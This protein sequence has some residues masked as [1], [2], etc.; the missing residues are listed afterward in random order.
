MTSA[1]R[2]LKIVTWIGRAPGMAST[3]QVMRCEI[4]RLSQRETRPSLGL[5]VARTT[6][7]AVGRTRRRPLAAPDRHR[8]R[9]AQP[10]DIVRSSRAPSGA[11]SPI[12]EADRARARIGQ[13]LAPRAPPRR[14]RR[15]AGRRR[16]RKRKRPRPARIFRFP[17]CGV[18]T[19]RSDLNPR[20]CSERRPDHGNRRTPPTFGPGARPR[21]LQDPLNF[22]FYHPLA[23][24]LARLLRPTGI[25]PNMVSVMSLLALIAAAASLMPASPGR[26]ARCSASRFMLAWHVDRRRRRRPRPDDAAAPRRPASWSTASATMPATSSSI[27]PSPS[28]STTG[29]APGPGSWR[30]RPAPAISSRPTMPRPSAALYLWR[31]YGVPWLRNAARLGRRRVPQGHLVHPL[32]RLLGGRL[33]LA[34]RTG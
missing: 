12:S 1:S 20:L 26:W 6:S 24:R 11:P 16:P 29:S 25:S 15:S 17:T 22:Y 5:P 2:A 23:A 34:L 27:S 33:C 3:S 21:E 30:S 7:Q 10:L 31:A 28:C 19:A 13:R 18:L 14:R 9:A 4:G 8:R 32:F